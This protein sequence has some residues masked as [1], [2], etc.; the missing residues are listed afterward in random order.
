MPTETEQLVVLLEARINQFER[1][2]AKASGTAGR[3]FDKIERRG[4]QSAR[5][6]EGLFS[7]IGKN[8]NGSIKGFGGGLLAG[9]IAGLVSEQTVRQ[10]GQV[11]KSVADMADEAER[12]KL[13]VE[14]FQA[15]SYA[16]RQ[17]G[18]EQENI[19][20]L[21]QKFQL[22]IGEAAT[23]GN[24]LT[25][26]LEANGI[27]IRDA[28]GNIREQK[29]L[30][31]EVVNLIKNAK[32][33]QEAALIAQMAFGKSSKES[34]AFLRQGAD[35]IREGE[36]AARS[37]GAVISKELVAKA[38]EFDDRWTAAWD[39]W[40]A[41]GKSSI[42]EVMVE[43]Q[44]FGNFLDTLVSK[45]GLTSDNLRGRGL[46]PGLNETQ[47]K[48]LESLFPS[49]ADKKREAA[50]VETDLLELAKKRA[51]LEAH[52][53]ELKT[54]DAA[55][56]EIDEFQARLDL[57][58][59][60][61][62][63]L[64]G[65]LN[66][67]RN[68]Q[69][70]IGPSFETNGRG[71]TP[72][73]LGST[74]I[75]DL[76]GAAK[77]LDDSSGN[78]ERATKGG[79]LDLVGLAEGTDQKRGYNE[80]LGFG[81]F[82]GGDQNLV[83][84]NLKEI[85][86]LQSKMLA[87]PDNQFNS[88]A[89]GRYQI[90]KRTLQEMISEL[91]LNTNDKFDEGMQDKIA[92]ALAARR[93]NNPAALKNEWEGLRR[94]PDANI[95]QAMG[96]S[97]GVIESGTTALNS[98]REATE[99]LTQAQ[100]DENDSLRVEAQAMGLSTF[101]A[102]KLTKSH[103]LLAQAKAQ[104]IPITNEL[105]TSI[106]I[107]ANEYARGQQAIEGVRRAQ[108]SAAQS[109]ADMARAQAQAAQSYQQLGSTFAGATKG[110]LQ[111][112]LDGKTATEALQGALKNLASQALNMAVDKIFGSL[113]SGGGAGKGGGAAKSGG[114]GS[115]L[116]FAQGGF[117]RGAGSGKS[118]SIPAMLSNGEYVI[119]ADATAKHKRLLEMIN[120][121][122]GIKFANGGLVGAVAIP[123]APAMAGSSIGGQTINIS[124]AVTVNTNGGGSREANADLSRQVAASVEAQ[125]KGL[126]RKEILQQKR[127][128]NMLA[129]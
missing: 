3:E 121:G 76:N 70:S 89:V 103:E 104:G 22:S 14:D 41:K 54:N 123:T 32:T 39:S 115:I 111:D 53:A 82:T 24:D 27:K 91:G 77:N 57:A 97:S 50:I 99:K 21:F 108:E 64:Q 94:V 29:E 12:V 18:L 107:L 35:A 2:M 26:V 112:L 90:T 40:T 55:P 60:K 51:E 114:I 19:T 49:I 9:G 125:L 129:S 11:V 128:G 5:K 65:K 106:G 36:K 58:I 61:I 43:V 113:F 28:N 10:L 92:S 71:G 45:S 74:V 93:G 110:F 8:I 124:S 73:S 20:D 46:V 80:T 52:I 96:N 34:L 38:A 69:L 30:F 126:V 118:D 100:R 56:I 59:D 62:T 25:K 122:D 37:A 33:Q 109:S 1:N 117:I 84:M 47:I 13:P 88:S 78:L 31:Y 85:M 79:I 42:L 86:A 15:L 81:A 17:S 63:V 101:E 127:V 66:A 68:A 7:N 72:S 98:R 67:L 102:A 95:N 119:N 4:Q 116:G 75:P 120:S 83:L 105:K 87:H 6:V 44:D 48:E 23:K 16:A